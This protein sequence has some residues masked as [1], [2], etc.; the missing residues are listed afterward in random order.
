MILLKRREFISLYAAKLESCSIPSDTSGDRAGI[1]EID[2][3]Q[4]LAE[5][6]GDYTDSVRLLAV[7]R[8]PLFGVSD[9]ALF[10]YA[11]E[12]G[13]VA[14]FPAAEEGALTALAA[15]VGEALVRIRSYWDAVRSMP[16]AVAFGRIV[17]DLGL[18]PYAAV[19]ETGAIRSGTLVKLIELIQQDLPASAAWH[20]LTAY[21]RRLQEADGLEGTSLFSGSGGAV[22]I[23]NLHKAKGLEAPVVFLAC[24]CGNNDHDA[25]EHVDRSVE[26]ALGYF[27]I[28]RDRDAYTKETVAQPAGWTEKAEK[29][30]IYQHAEEDRLLYVATTRAKQ[31]LVVSLYPDKPAID[32]W[33]KLTATLQRQP[34]LEEESAEPAVPKRLAGAP[35]VAVL[36]EPW[37]RWLAAAGTPTYSRTRVTAMTKAAGDPELPRPAEGRGMAF[38]SVVHRCIDALGGGLQ[39]ERLEAFVQ[40]AA[41]EEGLDVKWLPDAI[42]SVRRVLE[43]ELWRH[44]RA[45]KQAFHEFSF[46]VSEEDAAETQSPPR[47]RLLKGVIDLVFEEEDGWVIVDF[48]TDLFEEEHLGAFVRYYAPQ[49]QAY[50]EKCEKTLGLQVKEAGLYFINLQKYVRL[51]GEGA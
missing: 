51:E 38:G 50:A 22:R 17:E 12:M 39:P 47:L 45:A 29:E 26:P 9:E 2:A 4:T 11:M 20:E 25:E 19:R 30:R 21:L 32:P 16:A 6:L 46:M 15:P 33:S 43:S 36:L 3:L 41:D 37:Q 35:D 31:L 14:M 44:S 1:E 28:R 18:I 13:R 7:L 8:G 42:A 24:P 10:H 49:V 27:T 34:E 23:M 5:F 48:K 40:L